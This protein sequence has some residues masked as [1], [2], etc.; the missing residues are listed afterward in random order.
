MSITALPVLPPEPEVSADEVGVRITFLTDAYDY[1][2]ADIAYWLTITG[3]QNPGVS[4][5]YVEAVEGG[6]QFDFMYPEKIA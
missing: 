6:C 3:R 5:D 4:L 2:P 1:S